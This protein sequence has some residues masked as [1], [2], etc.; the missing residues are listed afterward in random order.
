MKT[1]II[2][3]P[4]SEKDIHVEYLT[5]LGCK[6]RFFTMENTPG[7]LQCEIEDMPE[8]CLYNF[9][10]GVQLMVEREDGKKRV[11]KFPNNIF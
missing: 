8:E 10:R 2:K 6:H 1:L 9:G 5:L 11:R 3:L 7:L 4:A